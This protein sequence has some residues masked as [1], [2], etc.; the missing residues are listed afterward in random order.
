MNHGIVERQNGG[1]H[2]LEVKSSFADSNDLKELIDDSRGPGCRIFRGVYLAQC[3][4]DPEHLLPGRLSDSFRNPE[5]P[6][7]GVWILQCAAGS[8]KG[9]SQSASCDV[10]R[11]P[12]E[13]CIFDSV[14]DGSRHFN[15]CICRQRSGGLDLK[16][17]SNR[18]I[19][20]YLTRMSGNM[21]PVTLDEPSATMTYIPMRS[22]PSSIA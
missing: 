14:S 15:K 11:I 20:G 2:V 13:K 21:R 17:P 3:R 18:P 6:R 16:C 4:V 9:R 12:C 8:I 1:W 7:T 5:S 10:R 22:M 19:R